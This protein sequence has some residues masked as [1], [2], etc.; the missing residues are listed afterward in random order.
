LATYVVA[1]FIAFNFEVGSIPWARLPLTVC[2]LLPVY[3]LGFLHSSSY[4]GVVRH[5]GGKDFTR[6]FQATVE[7][8]L[9]LL[10]LSFTT[11][12][13]YNRTA[14]VSQAMLFLILSVGGRLA[15]RS[16]FL[17]VQLR[18]AK[19]GNGIIIVGAGSMG[20]AAQNA[21]EQDVNYKDYVIA[22]LDDNKSKAGKNING[23][24]ILRA[25]NALTSEYVDKNNVGK[26]VVAIKNISG[27][28]LKELSNA[29]LEL[30]IEVSRVPP[31]SNWVNGEL[32]AKQIRP[33]S[34]EELLGRDPINLSYETL[35]GFIKGKTVLITGA[36]GSIGSELVRQVMRQ[37]PKLLVCLDQAETPI[38]HL[39]QELSVYPNYDRARLVIGSVTDPE[40]MGQIFRDFKPEVVFHAAAYKHVPLMEENPQEAVKTNILGTHLM[41]S[42]ASEHR[43][44]CFVMVSTDKAVNPTNIMGASKRAAEH[45]VNYFNDQPGNLTR[46]VTTRFGNV[47]GSNGSVIPLF[48]KQLQ[49]GG[50]ITLTHKDITRY[51]MTIP[52]AVRLVLEAGHMGK[53]G[54]ILVFD[55]GEPVK[56]YD[57]A[58]NLI[59]LSGLTVDKDIKIIVTGLRPGEKLYEELLADGETTRPTHHQQI[60]ISTSN[61]LDAQGVEALVEAAKGADKGWIQYITEY[62][63]AEH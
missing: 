23:I 18:K 19:K 42:L 30:G 29:A 44:E 2:I 12:I 26:L 35:N 4:V 45:V 43:A 27:V 31:T 60:F 11:A 10:V 14:L 47:L 22:Y 28:R 63:Q 7:A 34:L 5:S 13:E 16:M 9:F 41:S 50:P 21:I 6:L 62:E 32:T 56:I 36:A 52:E 15:V 58:V 25:I 46:F 8:T 38:Y 53:G 59:K 55:M 20:R 1:Q 3:A 61:N 39:D 51:F 48:K 49:E 57:L 33:I 54:E 37:K 17:S 40:R 24:P